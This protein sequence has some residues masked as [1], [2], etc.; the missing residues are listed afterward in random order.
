VACWGRAW[1]WA[2]AI[3][4]RAPQPVRERPHCGGCH[5][6]RNVWRG[7][8]RE[9]VVTILALESLHKCDVS[10]SKIR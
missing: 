4:H 3:G 6:D 8:G 10:L 1:N 7:G 5:D 9:I 2:L